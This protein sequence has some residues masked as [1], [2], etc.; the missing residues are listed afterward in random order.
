[1]LARCI[2]ILW[3]IISLTF[4][5]FFSGLVTS[6][7]TITAS[8][9]E[10]NDQVIQKAIHHKPIGILKNSH[11]EYISRINNYKYQYI[12]S[13]PEVF[14]LIKD[15]KIYAILDSFSAIDNAYKS[16]KHK[17]LKEFKFHHGTSELAFVFKK[18][19][20]LLN[21]VNVQL[22][23]MQEKHQTAAIFLKYLSANES[24]NCEI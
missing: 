17:D 20:P 12:S 11:A 1:M 18:N 8:S 7:L 13:Y 21:P 16:E 4:I 22:I 5:T 14:D 3:L 9:L 19:S 6:S 15:G 24:R 2:S 23:A 10:L